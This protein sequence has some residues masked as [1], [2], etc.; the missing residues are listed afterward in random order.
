MVDCNDKCK[1]SKKSYTKVTNESMKNFPKF[2]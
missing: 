2:I 1:E